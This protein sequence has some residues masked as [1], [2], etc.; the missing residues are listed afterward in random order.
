M[1]LLPANRTLDWLTCTNQKLSWTPPLAPEQDANCHL[2]LP[3]RCARLHRPPR[4]LLRGEQQTRALPVTSTNT[5]AGWGAKRGEHVPGF[6]SILQ[7]SAPRKNLLAALVRTRRR[8]FCDKYML[9]LHHSGHGH[10][11]TRFSM[12]YSNSYH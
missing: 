8:Y 1:Y 12:S 7:I 11:P 5:R 6:L 9:A 3:R 10:N 4:A 2:P